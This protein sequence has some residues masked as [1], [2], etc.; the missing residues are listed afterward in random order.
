MIAPLSH[1]VEHPL[2]RALSEEMHLR[3]MPRFAAPAR[4][5][6]FVQYTY[7]LDPETIRRHAVQL[8]SMMSSKDPTG[9]KYF[10]AHLGSFIYVWEQHTEVATYTFIRPGDFADPF[11]DLLTSDLPASWLEHL[12]GQLLRATQ[13]ALLAKSNQDPT[14]DELK[15]WFDLENLVCC[16]VE[17]GEARLW[18]NFRVHGNGFGRLLLQDKRLQG[19]SDPSQLVQRLQ[20]LGNYRNLALLGFSL[21]QSLS[22]RL[23]EMEKRLAGITAEIAAGS[24]D[25]DLTL[26]K[27][28]QLS[29]ELTELS[30]S[31]GFRLRATEAYASIVMERLEASGVRRVRGN[32]SL[33]D[34][35]ERRL[36]PAVRTCES[37]L[38]RVKQLAEHTTWASSLLRTRV[39]T[40]LE[41]QNAKLLASMD[42][43]AQLQLRLQQAVEGLSVSAITYY[44]T[45]LA[46]YVLKGVASGSGHFN[47]EI[48]VAAIVPIAFLITW[49]SVARLRSRN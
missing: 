48:W 35:T 25:D 4:V 36:A 24:L 22:P 7:G 44:M 49:M 37:V 40:A 26:A 3:Q 17:L 27:V 43:R 42:R 11:A 5:L 47:T 31:A 30:A 2:R 8:P 29:A 15:Q 16:D 18:S 41:A 32:R 14:D 10:Q 1:I 33:R 21:A 19:D 6:Q 38:Q 39:E 46:A 9:P 28:S 45:G 23:D 12:P 20:E 34:F 13:I